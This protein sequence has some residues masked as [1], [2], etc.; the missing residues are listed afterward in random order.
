ML[1]SN[2]VKNEV[3]YTDWDKQ[4]KLKKKEL[5]QREKRITDQEGRLYQILEALKSYLK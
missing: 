5:D 1:P 4:Y 2:E 3:N